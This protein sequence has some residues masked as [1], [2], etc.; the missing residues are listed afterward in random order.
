MI[1]LMLLQADFFLF[2]TFKSSTA[3]FRETK[4]YSLKIV[5]AI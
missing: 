5:K 2:I 1:F 4:E 3:L